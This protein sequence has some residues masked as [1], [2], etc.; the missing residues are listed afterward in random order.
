MP[1]VGVSPSRL[2]FPADE[3]ADRGYER[4][5]FGKTVAIVGPARTI[6]GTGRG[7]LIDSFDLVVRFNDMIEQLPIGP[8]LAADIGARADIFY[9]N[10]VILRQRLLE[11]EGMS[12][13]RFARMCDSA[14]IK[15]LVCT[16]NSL[17]YGVT[18]TPSAAC[19]ERDR[20]VPS[21]MEALLAAQQLSTRFRLM[22]AASEFARRWLGGNWGRTG[23]LAI[24]DL[25]SFD[26]RRLYVTGMTLFHG[27]GHLLAPPTAD[28]HPLRNRDG[29][30]SQS[31]A[32]FGHDSTLER[33]CLR[34]LARAYRSRLALDDN[35]AAIVEQGRC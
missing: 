11:Q 27:G 14:Q 19:D 8:R 18:G 3:T 30:S 32:G 21:R 31:P 34:S 23:F 28:L 10:Q 1:F 13:R 20:S 2:T 33:E 6:V 9:C 16:N 29:S 24:L 12:H 22:H 26:I 5:L 4:L 35:L 7:S 15:Y 25:L 17:S